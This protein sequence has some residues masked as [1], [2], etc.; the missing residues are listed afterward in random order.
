[1][2]GRIRY[3]LL[4]DGPFDQVLKY[5]IEW[6][7]ENIAGV[8]FDG[9]WANPDIFEGRARRLADRIPQ[10]LKY[11]PCDL[12]FIHR[13]AE[14]DPRTRRTQEI[15]RALQLCRS[16]LPAVCIVPV[17][18]T[19]AWLLFNETVIRSAAGNPNGMVHLDLPSIRKIEQVVNPKKRLS[20]VLV[21]ASE[22][23][24]R[25]KKRFQRDLPISMHRIAELINDF[26]PLRNLSAFRAFE[27]ELA[28][29]LK[30]NGWAMPSSTLQH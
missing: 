24:G 15:H 14:R 2:T 19:E 10:A 6:L 27:K 21:A 8:E 23:K 7:L 5:P 26:S 16:T 13:D 1:M 29:V 11:Y 12:L 20:E 18:M 30:E 22:R 17:R 4:T 25:S 28:G 9:E 3:T